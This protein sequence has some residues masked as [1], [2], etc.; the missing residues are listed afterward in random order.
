MPET[1]V[2]V[3]VLT[4]FL[5]AG[6]T[7]LLNW[8]LT[9]Q[10]GQR[11]AVIVNEF[12]EIGIDQDLIFNADEEIIEMNNGC[13]CC[14][15]R[16]DLNRILSQLEKRRDQF[17]RVL[18]ETTGLAN[19]GPVVLTFLWDEAIQEHFA[20]DG[21]VTVVD[22]MHIERHLD[23]SEEARAQI[24]FAD[25][26]V[27]NK[28][29]LVSLADLE[30]L[31]QRLRHANT[32]ARIHHSE[33]ARVPLDVL[34][35][36]GGFDLERALAVNPD[37]FKHLEDDSDVM[38]QDLMHHHHDEEIGSVS[39]ELEGALDPALAR[40]WLSM[41]LLERGLDIYRTKGILHLADRDER[42]V[43]QSV[44]MLFDGL[45]GRPW[46]ADRPI[47]RLV[48]IGRH[49]DRAFLERGLHSCLQR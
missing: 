7:T 2:P 3:T 25:V 33:Q 35:N 12:G 40:A 42:F 17:D 24:A 4:G 49:L 20:L 32:I 8:I 10:H 31:E 29:D 13:L 15:V 23:E 38:A 22:A 41:L 6:K 37:F 48:F 45:P 16:G 39:L 43:F 28:V 30:R 5:G 11:M 44:H 18:V 21:V 1:K 34:L 9:Q 26:F 19:P 36:L 14:T 46:G 47:N 27:L